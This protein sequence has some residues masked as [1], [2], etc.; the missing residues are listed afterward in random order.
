M[1]LTAFSSILAGTRAP[2]AHCK[3]PGHRHCSEWSAWICGYQCWQQ[4][5][6]SRHPCFLFYRPPGTPFADLLFFR[7]APC[8]ST[9]AF[10]CSDFNIRSPKV[11][12]CKKVC[13]AVVLPVNLHYLFIPNLFNR[14]D[15][16]QFASQGQGQILSMGDTGLDTS[17]CLFRDINV[18]FTGFQTEAGSRN[19]G[20]G[21]LQFFESTRHRKIRYQL[22]AKIHDSSL[23]GRLSISQCDIP[24][25]LQSLSYTVREDKWKK[26]FW[27]SC[28]AS[29]KA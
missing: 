6:L 14:V 19:F 1:A 18:P 5:S 25:H 17:H 7:V 9:K 21:S 27:M 11:L 3:F 8:Q 10:D 28:N 24:L 4:Q 12:L 15:P 29:K 20:G 23:Y 16:F 2:A 22:W 26:L 13:R